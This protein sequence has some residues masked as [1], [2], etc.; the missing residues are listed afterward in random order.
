[1]GLS[2]LFP[3]S[4]NFSGPSH[5]YLFAGDC[6]AFDFGFSV[7]RCLYGCLG[8]SHFVQQA[9]LLSFLHS[10]HCIFSYFTLLL[11]VLTLM[12]CELKCICMMSFGGIGMSY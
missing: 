1:M 3:V 4:S 6:R 5:L 10:S 9:S 8:R 2:L 7:P 11:L 12:Y